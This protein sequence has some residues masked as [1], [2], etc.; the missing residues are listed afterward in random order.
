[1]AEAARIQDDLRVLELYCG[2]G[3]MHAALQASKFNGHV[4][5]SFDIN[6][7][8][9]KI[10]EHNFPATKVYNRNIQWLNAKRVAKMAVNA[11]LMSPPCQPFTRAG[12]QKGVED[13]RCDSFLH[14]LQ[15]LPTLETPPKLILLE[16]VA[17]FEKSIARDRLVQVLKQMSY[18]WQEFWLSPDQFGIP[19]SRLRYFMV[20]MHQSCT[21]EPTS[22]PRRLLYH[23]PGIGGTFHPDY[24]QSLD[25]GVD[26]VYPKQVPE[27]AANRPWQ[28]VPVNPIAQ[29]LMMDPQPSLLLPSKVVRRWGQLLD[30]VVP[31]STRSLCFTKGYGHKVEGTGSVVQDKHD[32]DFRKRAFLDLAASTSGDA[33]Q[34]SATTDP[35][36]L[37]AELG[38]RYFSPSEM[39][40]LHGFQSGF[41]APET[42]TDKQIRK[43]IGNSLNVTV[44]TALLNWAYDQMH[45]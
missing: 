40:K 42:V 39:F 34:A 1:M 26:Y 36:P 43:A 28:L 17:G 19:N 38:L 11:W 20:A 10:Y 3:G 41:T 35:C 2:L 12:N 21:N 13:P 44:V 8:V 32:E 15:L 37:V 18:T 9:L 23:V 33:D 14:L 31:S 45:T 27:A 24:Q 7:I 25:E 5:S 29:Y 16:N 22:K 30:I 4:V 6:D